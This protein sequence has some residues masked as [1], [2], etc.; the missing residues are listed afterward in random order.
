[1]T[2]AGVA[3]IRSEWR[4]IVK[5]DNTKA[6]PS[7]RVGPEIHQRENRPERRRRQES[8]A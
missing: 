1:M 5:S 2:N 8:R 3:A 6:W 4:L 7:L